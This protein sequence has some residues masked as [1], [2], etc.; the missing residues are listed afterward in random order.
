[1]AIIGFTEE[2]REYINRKIT[3]LNAEFIKM[4]MTQKER[5]LKLNETAI[6][7]MKSLAGNPSIKKLK[8]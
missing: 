1:M 3:A 4:G 7:Q 2:D 8:P 5:L 6:T